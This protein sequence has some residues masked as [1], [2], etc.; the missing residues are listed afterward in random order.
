V[1]KKRKKKILKGN[2][3]PHFL[4]LTYMYGEKLF[5]TFKSGKENWEREYE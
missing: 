5:N 2:F 3:L 4:T 1:P